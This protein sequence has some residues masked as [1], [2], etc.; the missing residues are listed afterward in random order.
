M[1]SLIICIIC[2]FIAL[3]LVIWTGI[4]SISKG[5]FLLGALQFSFG[6]LF[7]I[8]LYKMIKE[9]DKMNNKK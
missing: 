9:F 7:S 4:V 6:I 3:I 2:E 8:F 5:M 1:K